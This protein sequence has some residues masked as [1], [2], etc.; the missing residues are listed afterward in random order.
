[1]TAYRVH[2][3]TD[4]MRLD[5]DGI[6]DLV[7][8]LAEVGGIPSAPDGALEVTGT[9]DAPDA[10]SA[11]DTVGRVLEHALKAMNRP[12]HVVGVQAGAVRLYE[13]S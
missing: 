8:R 10:R 11:V 6:D 1:M 9:T 7:W 5:D 13:P 12:C 4:L 3:V 2:F